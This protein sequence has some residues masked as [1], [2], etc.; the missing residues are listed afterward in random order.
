MRFVAIKGR[1]AQELIAYKYDHNKIVRG[2]EIYPSYVALVLE[3]DNEFLAHYQADRYSSGMM[4]ASLHET[5]EAGIE[6]IRSI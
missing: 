1:S 2:P 3:C 5:A 6:H 4:G